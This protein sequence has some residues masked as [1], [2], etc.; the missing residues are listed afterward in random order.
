MEK[1]FVSRKNLVWTLWNWAFGRRSIRRSGESA[2][3]LISTLL[4]IA[5]LTIMVVAFMQSMR[6]DRLTA[7]A[8]LDKTT[9]EMLA[10]AGLNEA[11]QKLVNGA[12][13][14]QLSVGSAFESGARVLKHPIAVVTTNGTST[15][16]DLISAGTS[17]GNINLI[18]N[19]VMIQ[20]PF[21]EVKDAEN[22]DIGFYG[23]W[24]DPNTSRQ[25]IQFVENVTRK[26]L[27]GWNEFP[28]LDKSST[29]FTAAE[30]TK[31]ENGRN[32]LLSTLTSNVLT[33][34]NKVDSY[35]FTLKSQNALISQEGYPKLNLKQLKDYLDGGVTEYEGFPES[36]GGGY[37]GLSTVQGPLS[38]RI[39]LIDQLLDIGDS[40]TDETNNNGYFVRKA[41]G[42]GSM[43][44][45]RMK[46]TDAEAKQIVA[47]IIDYIDEDRIPTCDALPGS[48][49]SPNFSAQQNNIIA[50]TP[51]ATIMGV[52][53]W[54]S[55]TAVF[56]HPYI[57][58]V[59]TGIIVNSGAN[60]MNSTRILSYFNVANPYESSIT[61]GNGASSSFVG[62]NYIPEFQFLATGT[63]TWSGNTSGQPAANVF[64]QGWLT[65]EANFFNHNTTRTIPPYTSYLHPRSA[66][67]GNDLA[68][69]YN[70]VNLNNVSIPDLKF[71]MD[72]GRLVYVSGG[73]R[74][75][76]QD[77]SAL[78]SNPK[79]YPTPYVKNS[80]GTDTIKLR[81]TG[82]SQN[83][84]WLTSDPRLNFQASRWTIATPQQSGSSDNPAVPFSAQTVGLAST[85]AV[86]DGPD[87]RQGANDSNL[88]YQSAINRH[89][90]TYAQGY[91][92]SPA[93]DTL[94]MESLSELGFIH[95]ARPWQTLR[96]HPT[97]QSS[98]NKEDWRFLDYLHNGAG[99]VKIGNMVKLTV[100]N[101]VNPADTNSNYPYK[102]YQ[103]AEAGINFNTANKL[104]LTAM[105]SDMPKV[106]G[107]GNYSATEAGVF[108]DALLGYDPGTNGINGLFSRFGNILSIPLL[109]SGSTF[110]FEKEQF[111][112]RF[113]NA[114]SQY[115]LAF[116]IYSKG[117]IKQR[118]ILRAKVNLRTE[119]VLEPKVDASGKLFFA[120]RIVKKDIE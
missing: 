23:Y 113:S 64:K 84:Y 46:Y 59:G 27:A 107:A 65:Q 103:V 32:F 41:W 33:S 24:V 93:V 6:I 44:W 35:N 21:V 19:D 109:T 48:T 9:A 85:A 82:P 39:A 66:S 8:Y 50:S 53:A 87:G 89:F 118:A 70:T 55:G 77:V 79:T 104:T 74:F 100:Q 112:A 1:E 97:A 86:V 119:V 17:T 28:L 20:V 7:R 4:I 116:T 12:N 120:P 52:E 2:F 36:L 98:A 58:Y 88:W 42:Y 111:Y 25:P 31:L 14:G 37:P 76:V 34:S 108:A 30:R 13:T 60:N 72:C 10:E 61:W 80:G 54:V 95:A 16:T 71:Q 38:P 47:N 78:R 75:L 62:L 90:P 49:P 81:G 51:A 56:G 15:V 83:D 67:S 94:P 26:N 5:I 18:D 105:F 40:D 117:E 63:A 91:R 96:I 68:N 99:L 115:P 114:Y 29:A 43:K 22:K 92:P 73:S 3:A 69:G 102:W 11:I 106:S 110:D 45:I 57:T 101:P